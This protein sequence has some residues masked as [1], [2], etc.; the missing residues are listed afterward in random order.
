[1]NFKMLTQLQVLDK[2][3]HLHHFKHLLLFKTF[4]FLFFDVETSFAMIVECSIPPHKKVYAYLVFTL[5]K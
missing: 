5:M 1:M 2:L 3:L 4:K